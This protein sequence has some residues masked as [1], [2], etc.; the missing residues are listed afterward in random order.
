M[1]YPKSQIKTNL[2][3]NGDEF[4]RSDNRQPYTGY[5]Y[6]TSKGE[7]YSGKNP[8]TPETI[9]L[10]KISSQFSEDDSLNIKKSV[11]SLDNSGELN[12]NSSNVLRYLRLQGEE[13]LNQPNIII[14]YYINSLPTNVIGDNNI[15]L[16]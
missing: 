9:L 7:S 15:R 4:I 11:L 14:P 3:T 13:P 2:Y 5:Y 16:I 12:V 10:I 1:Y 8:N 6:S